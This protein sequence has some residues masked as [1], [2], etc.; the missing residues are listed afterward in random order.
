[1]L[2]FLAAPAQGQTLGRVVAAVGSTAITASDVKSEYRLELFM[3][4]KLPVDADP[5]PATLGQVRQRII[6]RI[7]L[8]EEARADGIKLATNDK[9]VNARWDELQKKFSTPEDFAAGLRGLGLSEPALRENLVEQEQ[10]LRLIDQRLRP[11]AIVD[12]SEIEGYYRVTLVPELSRGGNQPPP[13]LS[14]VESRIREI[15]VQQRI[16]SLLDDWLKRLHAHGNV[17]VFGSAEVT[18]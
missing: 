4:G 11:Q 5:D 16:D 13:P 6:D 8:D 12:H 10:V 14:E 15:L 2:L 9:A 18:P 1:M 7:L 3:D 17:Q